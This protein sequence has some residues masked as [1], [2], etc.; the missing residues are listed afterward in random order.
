MITYGVNFGVPV[1]SEV[2]QDFIFLARSSL[3]NI[4][5]LR[6]CHPN[7][8]EHRK[9]VCRGRPCATARAV[10]PPTRRGSVSTSARTQ[11]LRNRCCHVWSI[12]G[13]SLV[14]GIIE[15]LLSEMSTLAQCRAR[16]RCLPWHLCRSASLQGVSPR[17]HAGT[18]APQPAL[19]R[20]CC[21]ASSL[22]PQARCS[23]S[24]TEK[25]KLLSV[26]L[27]T[28]FRERH[29]LEQGLL[30]PLADFTARSCVS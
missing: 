7:S 3:L 15:D 2:C 29:L 9:H 13:R 6:S 18:R 28:C 5:W 4:P 17:M 27:R 16:G 26:N 8:V 24:P 1:T 22:A 10:Q 20:H 30:T 25:R 11:R 23:Q 21:G 19:A 14:L 12:G